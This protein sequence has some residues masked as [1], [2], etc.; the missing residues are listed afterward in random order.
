VEVTAAASAFSVQAITAE[1]GRDVTVVFRNRDAVPHNLAFYTAPGGDLLFQ[2][3]IIAGGQVDLLTFKAPAEPGQYHFQCDL[4]PAQMQG[5]L[6][7]R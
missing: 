2:G 4:H 6:E 1:A 5:R 7:V 3:D